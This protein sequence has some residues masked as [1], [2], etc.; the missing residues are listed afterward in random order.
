MA[1]YAAVTRDRVQITDLEQVLPA[2]IVR[3]IGRVGGEV[4]PQS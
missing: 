3:E 1:D 4:A 2:Y